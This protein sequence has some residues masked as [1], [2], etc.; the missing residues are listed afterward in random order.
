MLKKYQNY[1]NNNICFWCE[2]IIKDKKLKQT[3]ELKSSTEYRNGKPYKKIIFET[4]I[5][6]IFCDKW[7][8]KYFMDEDD[9]KEKTVN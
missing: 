8:M 7:C 6:F 2:E 4:P 1:L 9:I 5:V 3:A